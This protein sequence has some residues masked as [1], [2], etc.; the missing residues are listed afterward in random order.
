MAAAT[1]GGNG[2][3]PTQAAASSSGNGQAPTTPPAN[4]GSAPSGGAPN[5]QAPT[6]IDPTPPQSLSADD[7]KRI[8][9]E[10]DEARRDAAR[11]RDELKKRD[12]AG[13]SQQQK[14]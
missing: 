8:R 4:N 14:L 11:Y 10:L 2:Q 1:G 9:Q 13:L 3:A 7:A 5:G 12:D 6:A